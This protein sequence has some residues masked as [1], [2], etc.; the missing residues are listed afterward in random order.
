MIFTGRLI[1]L[2]GL[3][4]GGLRSSIG[5]A[6]CTDLMGAGLGCVGAGF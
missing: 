5:A 1:L 2:V 3:D 4:A 6:S